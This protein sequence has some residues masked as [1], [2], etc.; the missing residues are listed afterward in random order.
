MTKETPTSK[1]EAYSQVV[2]QLKKAVEDLNKAVEEK[3][4]IAH[5]CHELDSQ[6]I[7]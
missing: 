5:R 1:D 4:E 3:E 6:V 7:L 2:E